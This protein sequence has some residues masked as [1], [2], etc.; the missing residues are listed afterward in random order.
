[1]ELSGTGRSYVPALSFFLGSIIQLTRFGVES[2][3]GHWIA[4]GGGD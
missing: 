3:G 2:L 1:M 4:A